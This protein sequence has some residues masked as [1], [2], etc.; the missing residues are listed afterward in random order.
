MVIFRKIANSQKLKTS[1][2][3]PI[4]RYFVSSDLDELRR[5]TSQKFMVVRLNLGAVNDT[6]AQLQEEA[7]KLSADLAGLK[8]RLTVIEGQPQEKL[9]EQVDS[10]HR[11]VS[12]F[13]STLM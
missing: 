4:I 10:I 3:F 11:E 6:V 2:K 8:S 1:P 9:I 5:E 13:Y 12:K 7:K